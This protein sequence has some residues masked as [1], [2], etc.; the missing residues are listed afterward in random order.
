MQSLRGGYAI[1]RDP[2][3]RNKYKALLGALN[4]HVS[5]LS[6]FMVEVAY[7]KE[8]PKWLEHATGIVRRNHKHLVKAVK[9]SLLVVS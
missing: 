3:L 8:G 6:L 2:T 5:E 1:I 4:L 7:S 9:G